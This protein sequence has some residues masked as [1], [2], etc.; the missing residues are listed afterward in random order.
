MQ[1]LTWNRFEMKGRDKLQSIRTNNTADILKGIK[2]LLQ[3]LYKLPEKTLHS[4]GADS[5][6]CCAAHAHNPATKNCM[7]IVHNK[8]KKH[9]SLKAI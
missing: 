2:L 1:Y 4:P 8:F 5:H 6:E 7:G 3:K 9:V